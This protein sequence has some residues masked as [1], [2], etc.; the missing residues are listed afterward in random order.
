MSETLDYDVRY[1]QDEADFLDCK[2]RIRNG[3]FQTEL[4][5]KIQMHTYF[6]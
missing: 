5:T 2:V 3:Q 4:Y 6:C 1:S